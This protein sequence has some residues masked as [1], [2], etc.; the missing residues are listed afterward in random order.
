MAAKTVENPAQNQLKAN[1]YAATMGVN[2]RGEIP[3]QREYGVGGGGS[4]LKILL[5]MFR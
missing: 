2:G 4:E 3:H 1:V 5:N